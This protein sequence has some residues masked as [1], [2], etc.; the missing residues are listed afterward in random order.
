MLLTL[1]ALLYLESVAMTYLVFEGKQSMVYKIFSIP[2]LRYELR[3][4]L[5]NEETVIYHHKLSIA[6]A[7]ARQF[8]DCRNHLDLQALRGKQIK[9]RVKKKR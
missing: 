8:R 2:D 7:M 1:S 3:G 9:T 6:L 4:K 5:N